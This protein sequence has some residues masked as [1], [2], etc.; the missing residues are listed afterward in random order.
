[1]TIDAH[2]V[3]APY[4]PD[5]CSWDDQIAAVAVQ[6]LRVAVEEQGDETPGPVFTSL[7]RDLDSLGLV[8]LKGTVGGA[9]GGVDR[10]LGGIRTLE[11]LVQ[12][13]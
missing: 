5:L 3:L 6:S 8:L 2:P 13:S 10:V 1:M 12:V 4:W 11:A 9:G 7:L